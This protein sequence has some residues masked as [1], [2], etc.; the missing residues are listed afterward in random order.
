VARALELNPRSSDARTARGNLAFQADLDW[1]R[2]EEEFQQA[3][4]LNPSSSTARTWYAYLLLV[5]QRFPEAKKQNLAAM[6]LDP[7]SRLPR[8]QLALTYENSGDYETTIT[9]WKKMGE[10]FGDILLVRSRL[11]WVYALAGRSEEALELM[12]PLRSASDQYSRTVRSSLLAQ[13]GRPEELRVL[14][15]EWEAGKST[16]YVSPVAQA[17]YYAQLGEREKAFAL[18]DQDL[19]GGDKSLWA[20]YFEPPF[21]SLRDDPRFVAMLHNMNL[22]TTLSRPR[23]KPGSS[24][25]K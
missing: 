3:I 21:D 13:L 1:P 9:L 11:A 25:P 5:L 20:R 18:L 22:P 10:A 24:S 12:N 19:R 14:L 6:E 23:P 4:A 17:E 16:E 7:L 2:A 15:T 8:V